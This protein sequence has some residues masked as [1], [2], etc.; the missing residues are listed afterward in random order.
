VQAPSLAELLVGANA[1]ASILVISHPQVPHFGGVKHWLPSM[2]F[3]AMLSGAAVARGVG[4]LSARLPRVPH[5]AL[6]ASLFALLL[7]PAL[8]GLARVHP[9][10]TSYYNELAGGLP[11]A[12]T[13]GMQRQFWSNNVTGVLPWLNAH[14]PQGAGLYLHEVNGYSF[15]DYQRNGMLRPDLRMVGSP[16]DADLAV[17]Q[18]HQEFREQEVEVWQAFGTQVPVT[19]LY[20]DETPQVVVYRR[21]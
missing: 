7:T 10:G 15:R 1:L 2:P 14:A 16:A 13:L 11:G 18:Y 9:Y 12:A 17:M 4:V 3:L 20:L 8:V 19:G 6:A 5:A 21:P